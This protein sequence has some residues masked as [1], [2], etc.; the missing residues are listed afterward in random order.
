M[1]NEQMNNNQDTTVTPE[2]LKKPS[3][4]KRWGKELVSMLLIVGVVSYA[5]D[6]YY[7]SD[8]PEGDAPQI[9]GISVQG[10]DIDV[11][12]LSQS[13]EPVI[14]Y[15]WATWCTACKFVSPTI[16]WFSDSHQVVSVALSSGD[17]ERVRRFLTAKDYDFPVLNDSSGQISRDWNISV[18]PT[19]VIIKDGQIKHTS[20]GVTTPWGLWLRTLFI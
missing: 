12:A 2:P 18:T 5:M 19:I 15:F 11:L 3:R 7:S 1:N 16:N 13:G 20:T 17:D 4:L 8:M 14:V 6:F 9:S 10:E